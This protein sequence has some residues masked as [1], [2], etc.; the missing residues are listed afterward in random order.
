METKPS[1]PASVC[2]RHT[3]PTVDHPTESSTLS[4]RGLI[5]AVSGVQLQPADLL[6][7]VKGHG[8]LPRRKVKNN[9]VP[10]V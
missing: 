7:T 1:S 2:V 6:L 5:R 3:A 9:Q 10:E 4:F 8:V